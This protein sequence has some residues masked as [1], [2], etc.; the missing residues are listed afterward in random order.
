MKAGKTEGD[1]GGQ[2]GGEQ[3]AAGVS[4]T[5]RLTEEEEKER[6]REIIRKRI[7]AQK[8][9]EEAEQ[10]AAEQANRDR[11]DAELDKLTEEMGR[12]AIDSTSSLH[13]SAHAAQSSDGDGTTNP[14]ECGGSLEV[15]AWGDPVYAPLPLPT[16][17][18]GVED[19]VTY[20]TFDKEEEMEAIVALIDRDLSEPYSILT[21]RYFVYNWS[22]HTHMAMYKGKCCGVV[23]GKL[24]H[25]RDYFRGYI[26]MLAVDEVL[27]GRGIGSCLVSKAIRSMRA[28]GCEEVVLE[29]ECSNTGALNLY[30]KLG[31]FRDKRL[32]R[33][34]LNGGDAFRLKLWF[35][36]VAYYT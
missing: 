17:E 25:H 7:A 22:Q 26:A 31:F 30:E 2:G 21:Y 18:A 33:Y 27:R 34:Y 9:A 32:L 6:K 24:E 20:K 35:P 19:G 16:H 3:G 10:K 8:A 12:A 36:G 23:I 29:T 14:Y 28:E 11:E 5:Q 13:T 4:E 15:D 1:A